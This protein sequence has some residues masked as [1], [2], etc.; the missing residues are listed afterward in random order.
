VSQLR[1]RENIHS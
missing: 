1:P